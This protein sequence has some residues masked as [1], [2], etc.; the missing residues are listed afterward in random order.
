MNNFQKK[1]FEDL[2]VS[3]ALFIIYV[4]ISSVSVC[5]DSSVAYFDEPKK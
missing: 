3:I 1:K 4:V 5:E 2:F